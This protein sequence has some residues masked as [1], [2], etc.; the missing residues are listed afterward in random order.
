MRPIAIEAFTTME[1]HLSEATIDMFGSY[2]MAVRRSPP[3]ADGAPSF[4]EHSLMAV[5]GYAGEKVRGA[6]VMVTSSAA[7]RSWLAA[8]GGLDEN[9]DLYDTLGEF[10]NMLL[11]RL[12]SRLLPEGFPILLST[13]TTASGGALHVSKPL[14]PSTLLA[15]DGPGWRLD[16]RVD[17]TFEDGF[18]LQAREAREVPAAAGDMMLF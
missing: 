5:I 15:F 4:D 1:R 7:I 10:S 11:G 13:P 18:E 12:K 8:L 17:A 14:W 2:G 3:P 16:V 6:L 9:T